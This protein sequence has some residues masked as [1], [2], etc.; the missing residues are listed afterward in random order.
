MLLETLDGTKGL[1]DN[2]NI[3]NEENSK[4]MLRLFK[5]TCWI[6]IKLAWLS[7]VAISDLL[8]RGEMLRDGFCS[9]V[10][11]PPSSS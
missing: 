2:Q 9:F 5:L 11:L 7:H 3:R 10:V 6:I 8:R 4:T 1:F